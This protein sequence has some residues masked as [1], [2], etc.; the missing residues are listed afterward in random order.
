M[1]QVLEYPLG[2]LTVRLDGDHLVLTP[3]LG[4]GQPLVPVNDG[5]FRTND[6]LTASLAFTTEDGEHVLAG[7]RV[8]A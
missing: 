1:L 6:E 8:Y 7:T 3:T 4:A 2:G 5:L